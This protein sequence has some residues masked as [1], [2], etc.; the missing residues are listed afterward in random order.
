[1]QKQ[2]VIRYK[3]FMPALLSSTACPARVDHGQQISYIRKFLEF[4]VG[5]VF[6]G[7]CARTGHGDHGAPQRDG[8]IPCHRIVP[9]PVLNGVVVAFPPLPHGRGYHP[10]AATLGWV[11]SPECG[12]RGS[13]DVHTQKPRTWVIMK[14][15]G[16]KFI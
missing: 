3:I 16:F 4:G 7:Y 1:M 2:E 11:G 12:A 15:P 5:V 9:A 6:S 13:L 8:G 10:D 14:R